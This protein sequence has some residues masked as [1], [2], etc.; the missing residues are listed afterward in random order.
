MV[1][2]EPVPE[3]ELRRRREGFSARLAEAGLDAVFLPPSSDLE[4]LTG[5]E[6]DVP[7]FGQIAY[8]HGWTAG[9]FLAPGREPLFVL[10][11]MV[12]AFHLGGREPGETVVVDEADDG[13]ALF[14]RAAGS[15]GKATRIGIGARTWAEAVLHLRRTLPGAE[16]ENASPLVNELR[17]VK[18]AFELELMTHACRIAEQAM[19]DTAPRVQPGVS[20]LELAEEIEHRLRLHGSRTPSFPTHVFTFGR[21]DSRDST[22]ATATEPIGEGEPVMFTSTASTAAT[23]PTSG[24]RSSAASRR[25]T[26]NV[27]TRSC[28]PPRR[29]AARPPRPACPHVT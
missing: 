25:R 11:R 17:R 26:T 22:T 21:E 8:S 27:S 4:Y 15:L 24:A 18:S 23:A 12:I 1:T 2:W 3:V 29:Q 28:S 6:R 19:V 10:P 13:E 20:T 5:L 16:L 9:A 7:S 14:E